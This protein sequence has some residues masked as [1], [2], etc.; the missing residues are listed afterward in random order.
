MLDL[1]SS[2]QARVFCAHTKGEVSKVTI[3]SA[4]VRPRSIHVTRLQPDLPNDDILMP[5]KRYVAPRGIE[6]NV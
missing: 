4:G 2:I 6:D 5:V 1:L 3:T